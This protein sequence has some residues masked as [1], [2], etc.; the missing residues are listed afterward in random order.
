MQDFLIDTMP[1][2][3]MINAIAVYRMEPIGKPAI[4][5]VQISHGM[6]EHI[7]RYREFANILVNA[8]YIVVGNDHLGHGKTSDLGGKDGYFGKKGSHQYILSDLKNL[9]DETKK[10]YGNLPYFMFGHS[11]GSFF[12]RVFCFTYNSLP[13]GLIISGTGGPNSLGVVAMRLADIQIALKGDVSYSKM[14]NDLIFKNFCLKIPEPRT[15]MDWLTRNTEIVDTY[16]ADKKC[17]FSF[18]TSALLELFTINNKA[19]NLKNIRKTPKTLPIIILS[20]EEDPVGM[21]GAGVVETY[22][23][24]KKAGILDLT[25]KLYPQ[26]RHELHNE[27]NKEEVFSQLLSWINAHN[28]NDNTA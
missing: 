9:F 15:S 20:G 11:M 14:L 22:E 18:T 8:G 3:N 2:S 5:I 28:K 21:F 13:D 27:L 25:I 23:M 24:Y 19:N 1:S 16:M 12:A 10:R 4:G 7:Q 26:A 17:T 6:T